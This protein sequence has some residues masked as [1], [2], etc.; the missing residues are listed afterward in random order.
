MT[1]IVV[2]VVTS[3]IIAPLLHAQAVSSSA[4][5]RG[6]YLTQRNAM[7][8]TIALTIAMKMRNYAR[9]LNRVQLVNSCAIIKIARLLI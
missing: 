1:M 2:M 6:V 5:I 7:V 3:H 8:E 9:I 4:A